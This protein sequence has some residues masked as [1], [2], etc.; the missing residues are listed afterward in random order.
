MFK[1]KLHNDKNEFITYHL[2][3]D[4]Y[5]DKYKTELLY[6]I[7]KNNKKYLFVDIGSNIG[8]FSLLCASF[9]LKIISF[10]PISENYNLFLDSIKENG[11]ENLINLKK[12]GLGKKRGSLNFNIIRANMGCCTTIDLLFNRKPDYISEANIFLGDDYLLDIEEDM[13]VKID[14][15]NMEKDVIEGLMNT[16]KKGNIKFIFIEISKI[17]NISNIS[18]LELFDILSDLKYTKGI[19]IDS[20]YNYYNNNNNN[21]NNDINNINRNTNYLENS[22]LY[23]TIEKIKNIY[24]DS[25]DITQM[26][27]LLFRSE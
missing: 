22:L 4:G 5:W 26:D 19:I 6:E 25:D 12:V 13:I 18:N 3:K 17:S 24:I 1:I 23:L 9:G 20:I 16:L 8:Y 10:E 27:L 15:E 14:V 11:Y 2:L 7:T 21:D